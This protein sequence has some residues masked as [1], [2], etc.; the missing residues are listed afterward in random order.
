MRLVLLIVIKIK[1]SETC[2]FGCREA[3]EF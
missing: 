3:D 1:I 2:V